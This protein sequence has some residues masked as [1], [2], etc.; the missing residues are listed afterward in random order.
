[1]SAVTLHIGWAGRDAADFSR[2]F[3]VAAS[4]D[5]FSPVLTE[6]GQDVIA[7]SIAQNFFEGGRP[8][9]APLAASTI[10]KKSRQGVNNPTRVLVHSGALESAASN[11]SEYKVTKDTLKAAPFSIPYWVYHQSGTP[12]MP[13]RLVMM[14]QAADRTAAM[15][16]FANF[17]RLFKVMDPRKPGGRQF[18]GGKRF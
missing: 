17:L 3:A 15:R 7:P 13:Q 16:K 5:D 1:V 11:F 12:K 2:A 8:N 9:W 14:M 6:I 10:A 4:I 18:T